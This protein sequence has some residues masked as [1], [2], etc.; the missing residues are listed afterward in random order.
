MGGTPCK[1][2]KNVLSHCQL[3]KIL[4]YHQNIY[5]SIYHLS[6][7]FPSPNMKF[8]MQRFL[9]KFRRSGSKGPLFPR[10]NNEI[11]VN[12]SHYLRKNRY[13]LVF[14]NGLHALQSALLIWSLRTSQYRSW[15]IVAVLCLVERDIQKAA[16]SGFEPWQSDPRAS[17]ITHF[18]LRPHY[19]NV[20]HRPESSII[21]SCETGSVLGAP[22]PPTPPRR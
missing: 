8:M 1:V 21:W 11:E 20:V 22:P 5:V 14:L 6:S 13:F 10:C 19:S 9:W 18:V 2:F 12:S 16:E 15:R 7:S 3:E 4:R 17:R